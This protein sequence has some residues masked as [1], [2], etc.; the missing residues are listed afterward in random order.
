MHKT[1]NDEWAGDFSPVTASSTHS[2][3]TRF[4]SKST[5]KVPIANSEL[6][7]QSLTFV[8]PYI[9]N[10]LPEEFKPLNTISFKS[11]YKKHLINSDEK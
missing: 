4:A 8:G 5:F 1:I 10:N 9:W 3:N 2:H 7:K 6:F 11:Q